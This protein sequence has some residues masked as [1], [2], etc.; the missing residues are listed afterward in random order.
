MIKYISYTYIIIIIIVKFVNCADQDVYQPSGGEDDDSDDD[1]YDLVVRELETLIEEDQKSGDTVVSDNIMEHGLGHIVYDSYSSQRITTHVTE[2]EK[3][4]QSLSIH[5]R[6]KHEVEDVK[7]SKEI[8]FM[9]KDHLGNFFPMTE[10]DY[11]RIWDDNNSMKYNFI[12]KVEQILYKS[13]TVYDHRPDRAYPLSLTYN[14]KRKVFILRLEDDGFLYINKRQGQWKILA[15]KIPNYVKLY[16]IDSEGNQFQLSEGQ[17]YLYLTD[18]CCFKYI[19]FSEIPCVKIIANN[20]LVWEKKPNENRLLS[21]YINLK[22]DFLAKFE[23]HIS[24]I[25]KKHN[26]YKYMFDKP[27]K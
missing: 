13:E 14:K 26:E 15:R 11:N 24:V 5:H 16:S 12:T 8:I 17:Y 20:K 6:E 10:L 25:A 9:K 3:I 4:K 23:S 27:G 7:K 18:K 21:V 1:N 19:F 22:G 2:D